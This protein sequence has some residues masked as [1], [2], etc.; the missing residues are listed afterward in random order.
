MTIAWIADTAGNV[1]SGAPTIDTTGANFLIAVVQYTPG[2]FAANISDSYSNTWIPLTAAANSSNGCQVYY[3][4]NATVGV[5]H[6]FGTTTSFSAFAVA[7]FS[8]VNTAPLDQQAGSANAS[9]T[10]TTIQAGSVTPGAANELVIAALTVRNQSGN[11]TTVDSG[12]T[13][14]ASSPGVQTFAL[15]S[16]AYLIQTTATAENPTWTTA[17]ATF[18]TAATNATFFGPSSPPPTQLTGLGSLNSFGPLSAAGLSDLFTEPV[19]PS[20]LPKSQL[21]VQQSVVN[22]VSY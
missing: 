6:N 3:V 14:T 19:V 17:T 16:L 10:T 7:A 11:S 1:G 8:G 15:A 13:E 5:G 18:G 22:A 21:I 20:V 2:S 4:A 9:G 12:F